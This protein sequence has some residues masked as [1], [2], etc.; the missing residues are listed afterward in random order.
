MFGGFFLGSSRGSLFGPRKPPAASPGAAARAALRAVPS[1]GEEA[2]GR[3]AAAG[4]APLPA[5]GASP[6]DSQRIGNHS[7]L[8]ALTGRGLGLSKVPHWNWRMSSDLVGRHQLL[9]ECV[10]VA[11]DR[12]NFMTIHCP[13]VAQALS[14]SG[15]SA[16]MLTLSSR[17]CWQ[18]L[19]SPT[20]VACAFQKS[21][22]PGDGGVPLG[23]LCKTAVGGEE[24]FC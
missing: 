24:H 2:L 22:P 13:Q 6:H 19:T 14:K 23:L 9:E 3:G 8:R 5:A 21:A 20:L 18:Y 12:R 15:K 16:A 17:A 4:G 11:E 7:G 1:L 10:R